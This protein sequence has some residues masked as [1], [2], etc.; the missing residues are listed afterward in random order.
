MY[1]IQSVAY[2]AEND[3]IKNAV[4]KSDALR[5]KVLIACYGIP[6]YKEL[7][8]SEKNAIYDHMRERLSK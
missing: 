7:P 2:Y 8:L 6:G 1:I 4:L 3:Q 5:E